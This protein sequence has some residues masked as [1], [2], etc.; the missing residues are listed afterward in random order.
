MRIS[1]WSSDVCSSDL[2]SSGACSSLPRSG[3]AAD[4]ADVA[5]KLQ[6][7][8]VHG[9]SGGRRGRSAPV[10]VVPDRAADLGGY[11]RD[12]LAQM[13]RK[14]G[15]RLKSCVEPHDNWANWDGMSPQ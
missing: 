10:L 5:V 7:A 2:R 15:W 9:L 1:D 3:A 12:F 4:E 6:C 8:G 11:P 13:G 14:P